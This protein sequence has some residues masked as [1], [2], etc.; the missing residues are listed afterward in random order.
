MDPPARAAD[1]PPMLL[2]SAGAA[3][4]DY[5]LAVVRQTMHMRSEFT[6]TIVCGRN[7]ALRRRIEQLVAPAGDRYRVL[8]FTSEMPQ[9]LQRADLFIGKPGGLSASECM[10]AGLPMVLVNPIPGQEVRN[11]DYLME[12]GA[13]VRCNSTATIGWKIDELL[14]EPGRL[15]R[16]QAAAAR[17]GRPDA[18]RD[19]VARVLDG[20]SRPLIVTRAA[21]RT[22][23]DASERRIVA[24]DLTG[25][26][27]LVRLVD[28]EVGSTVALLRSEQ[29]DDLEARHAGVGEHL[30]LRRSQAASP[31]G[32]EVRRL[33]RGVL[34]RTRRCPS[35]A[36]RRSPRRGGE[37]TVA[38]PSASP[39]LP[40][41]LGRSVRRRRPTSRPGCAARRAAPTRPAGPTSAEWRGR[42]GGS[43]RRP[44]RLHGRRPVRRQRH[45]PEAQQ[46]R[47]GAIAGRRRRRT[48]ARPSTPPARPCSSPRPRRRR[49]RRRSG[50]R[51][52]GARTWCSPDRTRTGRT[53]RARPVEPAL[54]PAVVVDDGL[55]RAVERREV[56]ASVGTTNGSRP[57]GSARPVSTSASARPPSMPPYQAIRSA[58][59][60]RRHASVMIAL[61]PMSTTTVRGFAAATARTRRTSAGSRSS[62]PRSPPRTKRDARCASPV[63]AMRS[64]PRA[65]RAAERAHI[66][67]AGDDGLA[68]VVLVETDDHDRGVRVLRGR[69]RQPR[70]RGRRPRRSALPGSASRRPCSGE[71]VEGG[72]TR[73]EP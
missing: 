59:T 16:M 63:R 73:D 12:Q 56:R 23:L 52:D 43:V 20:P 2:I 25:P 49:P 28:D 29:L 3:G 5:A 33:L 31:F 11:G 65:E 47:R 8:G 13:A 45:P 38:V 15:Q 58:G 7:D 1:R 14:G 55:R 69:G 18:A 51:R 53:A 41:P 44:A 30:V 66:D 40:E 39:R 64:G 71:T 37:S 60:C 9:L 17:T 72:R 46:L 34:P 6:A 61:P 70:G 26:T 57:P 4:G 42:A 24:S 10:A 68:L 21:Q 62:E 27:S 19:A 36:S 50:D 35:V 22:I 48:P 32:W 67:A 54:A